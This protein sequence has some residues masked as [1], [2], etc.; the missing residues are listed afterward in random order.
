MLL[1]THDLGV[2]AGLADRVVVMY[3]GRI[4][5]E[6][7]LDDLFYVPRHPYT[8]GLLGS[9]PQLDSDRRRPLAT[10]PGTPPSLLGLPAGCALAPRCPYAVER[11][12]QVRPELEP[13][14]GNASHRSA[15]LRAGE[16][17]TLVTART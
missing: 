4:V 1:I 10:I 13:V 3:A 12:T 6:G 11:C 8:I 15:C 17:P 2:V 14:D 5:E 7:S 9:L 16:L